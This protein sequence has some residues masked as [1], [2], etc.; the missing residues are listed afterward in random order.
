MAKL[1][2]V[3][4]NPDLLDILQKLFSEEHE[5]ETAQQGDEAISLARR[6]RPDLVIL[7]MQLPVMDGREA[8]LRIK[9]LYAPEWVP[10]LVLTALAQTADGAELLASGCCDAF[11]TKPAPLDEIRAHVNELLD[12]GA[13]AGS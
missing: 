13:A 7:D 8:G 5:V 3:E 12:Q 6:R 11:L 9:A 10:I 1:L 4:D 2:I